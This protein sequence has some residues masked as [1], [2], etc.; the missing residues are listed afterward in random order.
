MV[1][2]PA[3]AHLGSKRKILAGLLDNVGVLL[4]DLGHRLSQGQ[5]PAIDK[6]V[7]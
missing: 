5:Q 6:A 3:S 4:N 7:Q 1:F 2:I